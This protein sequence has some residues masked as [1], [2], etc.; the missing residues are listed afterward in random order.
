MPKRCWPGCW[1]RRH[2]EARPS[3]RPAARRLHDGRAGLSRA[4]DGGPRQLSRAIRR[5]SGPTRPLVAWVRRCAVERPGRTGPAA[6]P[7]HRTGDRADPRGAG[8]GARRGSGCVAASRGG[9]LGHAPADQRERDSRTARLGRGRRCR[10]RLPGEEFTTWRAG[11]D[12]SWELDLFG[13][14]APRTRGGGG[15]DRRC[16]LEP[17]RR[18]SVGRGRSR[19]RLSAPSHAAGAASPMPRPSWR[20]S[21]AS[22]SWSPRGPAAGWS[23][24]RIW[25]SSGRNAPPRPPR[26]RR[27]QA[28]AKAEIH[29]LGVLTGQ[30]PDALAS[31]LAAPAELAPSP[32]SCPPACRRTCSG[33]GRIS[34]PPSASWPPRPPTSASPWPTSIR[35][36]R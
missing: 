22:S 23:P 9:S 27:S 20:A 25:S 7:R 33:G 1:W 8:A 3:R 19:E 6:E 12:A 26:S 31:Q 29:A 18:R 10:L 11:F 13:R 16:H 5:R 35:A 32:P 34:A 21:S 15:A 36:F 4:A 24:A 30:A 2:R 14:N 28:Q 17:A